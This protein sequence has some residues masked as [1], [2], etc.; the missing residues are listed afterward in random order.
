VDGALIHLPPEQVVGSLNRLVLQ[1]VQTDH[2]LTLFLADVDLQTGRVVMVQAGHPNPMV[3][4]HDGTLEILG[5]G[6]LPVGL[7]DCADY[8]QFDCVLGPGDRLI[9][10]SDG[11]LECPD[12][13]ERL[14]G[15]EGAASMLGDLR[16][17]A[18]TAFL[19][20]IIWNLT[21]YAGGG[22]FPD[23]ISAILFEY[24]GASQ[25]EAPKAG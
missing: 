24:K 4:R 6:G 11:I 5:E 2:Y 16:H 14:L 17:L 21:E 25:S 7:F 3:Q 15:T 23:D 12:P 19:E 1:E 9:V 10:L 8:Q 13:Q 18:G 22:D 20:A